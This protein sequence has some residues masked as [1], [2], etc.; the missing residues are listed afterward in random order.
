MEGLVAGICENN[1]KVLI[2][3]FVRKIH[4]PSASVAKTLV[5]REALL[6]P[7]EARVLNLRGVLETDMKV[8]LVFDN[9]AFG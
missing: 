7:K 1:D 8:E 6:W 9:L 4:A 3:G 2:D 5:A